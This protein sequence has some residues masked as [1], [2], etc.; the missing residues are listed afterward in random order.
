LISPRIEGAEKG[1]IAERP[2]LNNM[3]H[4]PT[5]Q[6]MLDEKTSQTG[7]YRKAPGTPSG[8]GKEAAL[9]GGW[10]QEQEGMDK[11]LKTAPCGAEKR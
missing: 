10:A 1:R 9:P 7:K 5:I 6:L 11:I 2:L 8:R 4:Y 3:H